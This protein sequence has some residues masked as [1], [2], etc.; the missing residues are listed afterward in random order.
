VTTPNIELLDK[1][2]KHIEDHPETWEQ[3]V[4]RTEE[5]EAWVK[6]PET[7]VE[8][9]TVDCGTAF[10]FAGWTCQME[11]GKWV[12]NSSLLAVPEDEIHPLRNWILASDRAERLLGLA[13]YEADALFRSEN[14]LEDIR[15]IVAQ[16]KARAA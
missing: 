9:L 2:L 7:G 12:D 13:E 6:D 16:I 11:G 15:E 4:W 3:E 14:T 10:C 1:V 8:V 5:D